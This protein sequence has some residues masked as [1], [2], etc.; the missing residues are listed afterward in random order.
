MVTPE[1]VMSRIGLS[2]S[3]AEIDKAVFALETY[4]G[5]DYTAMAELPRSVVNAI[6]WQTQYMQSN[7]D[8]FNAR[9]VASASANGVSISY[10]N[11]EYPNWLSPLAYKSL[12]K[13]AKV[14]SAKTTNVYT[15]R[16]VYLDPDDR[17]P[18]KRMR[19]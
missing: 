2:V 8:V 7:P 12:H 14:T 5:A 1:I 15:Q 3:Q 9:A 11:G 13:P 16:D 6:I 17:Y 19:L 10:A 18:W 4:T